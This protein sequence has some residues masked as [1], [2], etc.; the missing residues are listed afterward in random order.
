MDSNEQKVATLFNAMAQEYDQLEDEWYP[1]FFRQVER[2]L[3]AHVPRGDGKRALDVGCGT[4]LQTLL[5]RSLD[6]ETVGVDIAEELLQKAKGKAAAHGL[7]IQFQKASALE[8]PFSMETFDLVSCCGSVLGFVSDYQRAVTELARVTK[9]EGTLIVEVDQRWNLDLVWGL[10][11]PLVGGRL[12]Y[13]QPFKEALANL[14]SLPF[15]GITQHYPFTRLDGS[16]D[17]MTVRLFTLREI[18]VPFETLGWHVQEVYGVHS[19]SNLLP[20]TWL[21]HPK[22]REP[23]RSI[24]RGLIWCDAKIAA[25]FPFNRIANNLILVLRR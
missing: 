16:T 4:G 22:L 3:R 11:D 9:R 10:V 24:A 7:D 6:Y 20:S 23:W 13:Q 8:L 17:T 2:V 25:F 19:I 1:H 14:T 21:A 5:I 15:K 18:L 12:G